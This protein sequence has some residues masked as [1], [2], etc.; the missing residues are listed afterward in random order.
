MPA[1]TIDN[2]VLDG[3]AVVGST[4]TM[5]SLM[6]APSQLIRS[7][8]AVAPTV[9]TG[10]SE[11]CATTRVPSSST[12]AFDR[13]GVDV[14]A[15]CKVHPR[16][17]G[18][19]SSPVRGG[20]AKSVDPLSN[21][22]V[23]PTVKDSP[24]M[25]CRGGGRSID[26]AYSPMPMAAMPASAAATATNVANKWDLRLLVRRVRCRFVPMVGTL[27][28][29]SRFDLHSPCSRGNNRR[30]VGLWRDYITGVLS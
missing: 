20:A 16:V 25:T 7:S 21:N 30:T 2:G 3:P 24:A 22:G 9:T 13:N 18:V 11:S 29:P 5:A 26:Q 19:G 15:A 17:S 4:H 12:D 10:T 8:A 23:R 6:A 27:T 1:T 14:V 28:V